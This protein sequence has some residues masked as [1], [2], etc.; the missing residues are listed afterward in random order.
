MVEY[1]K[2]LGSDEDDNKFL[3]LKARTNEEFIAP[4]VIVGTSTLLPS[5]EWVDKNKDNFLAI[6]T[7]EKNLNENP[8][9]IGFLPLEKSDATEYNFLY[10][11]TEVLLKLLDQLGKAKVNTQIGP[12]PFMADTIKVLSELKSN[13]EQYKKGVLD[14]K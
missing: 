11:C 1:V 13:V 14:A 2:I 10:L 8:L 9:I 5:K 3:R 7:Y 12:Q 4:M 6:V